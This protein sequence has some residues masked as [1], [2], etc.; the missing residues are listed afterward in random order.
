MATGPLEAITN[1]LAF[2]AAG[3]LDLAAIPRMEMA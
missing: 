1:T 3:K 2:A